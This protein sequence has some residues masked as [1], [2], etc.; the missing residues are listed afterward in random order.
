M[1]LPKHFP[2]GWQEAKGLLEL[3]VWD[4]VW[5]HG[6]LPDS[7]AV[8][9]EERAAHVRKLKDFA[10]TA[11]VECVAK[12]DASRNQVTAMVSRVCV[13]QLSDATFRK[14]EQE[15]E[16][17]EAIF[18]AATAASAAAVQLTI[19]AGGERT[20]TTNPT[21]W[22]KHRWLG[23]AIDEHTIFAVAQIIHPI[24]N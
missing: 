24:L 23:L 9:N 5:L 6:A 18:P 16:L 13:T 20:K 11:G 14:L 8:R 2:G 3:A 1:N 19:G 10:R 17:Y 21:Q 7:I 12:D 4:R 15:F 22:T